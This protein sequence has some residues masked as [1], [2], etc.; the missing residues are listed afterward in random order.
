MVAR[1]A[2]SE[3]ELIARLDAIGIA[4]RTYRHKAVFTVDEAKA[5]RGVL[6]GGHCK[7]LFLKDRRDGLW[8]V[9]MLE[10]RR[11][12]LNKLSDRLGAPRFSFGSAAL[13]LDVLGIAPGSVTPFAVINDTAGRVTVVLD[14]EMLDYP[15]LNYHPLTN[16]ATTAVAPADLLRFL[17]DCG[18]APRTLH[19][20]DLEREAAP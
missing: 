5:H 11:T 14:A 7:S 19:L 10:H 3:A 6:P 9:V 15:L 16:E 4:H 1:M 18:H 12:D 2:A 13:L 8:L 17:A 20:S